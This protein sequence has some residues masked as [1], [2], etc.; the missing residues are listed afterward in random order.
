M[1]LGLALTV[2]ACGSG[3][4]SGSD[5]SLHTTSTAATPTAPIT[6]AGDWVVYLASEAFNGPAGSNLNGDGDRTDAVAFAVNLR[7]RV[8]AAVW[9][10]ERKQL[11]PSH[12]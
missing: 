12:R 1:A 11:R 5:F 6:L 2:A 9:A 8:E 7:S 4:G 3:G 10:V